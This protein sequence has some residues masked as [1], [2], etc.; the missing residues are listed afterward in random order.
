MNGKAAGA[1]MCVSE[2]LLVPDRRKI[3][4]SEG[5][6]S[7]HMWCKVAD[8]GRDSGGLVGFIPGRWDLAD[9]RTIN[10]DFS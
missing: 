4:Q 10:P 3:I 6:F 5:T 7:L 9:L 2:L 1:T 8:S